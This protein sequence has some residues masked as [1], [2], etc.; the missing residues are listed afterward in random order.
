MLS[1]KV[2]NVTTVYVIRQSWVRHCSLLRLSHIVLYFVR[3][4][5]MQSLP[6]NEIVQLGLQ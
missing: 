6:V 3:F 2:E 4:Q 1:I 5:L